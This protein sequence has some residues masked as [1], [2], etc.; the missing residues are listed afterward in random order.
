MKNLS[1]TLPFRFIDDLNRKASELSNNTE[2]SFRKHIG[3]SFTEKAKVRNSL[4]ASLRLGFPQNDSERWEE[5]D[6]S[7]LIGG[8]CPVGR[9]SGRKK[10]SIQK[11]RSSAYP[12]EG[13]GFTKLL[14]GRVVFGIWKN[15]KLTG[16]AKIMYPSADVYIGEVKD[17]IRHGTGILTLKNGEKY[18]GSFKN[19]KCEG[20]GTK[21]D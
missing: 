14:D 7:K 15:G 16:N 2:S 8:T 19:G 3:P 1:N 9:L 6:G 13:E 17:Y 5:L 11:K 20:Y 12:L 10:V 21:Y 4:Q 18:V